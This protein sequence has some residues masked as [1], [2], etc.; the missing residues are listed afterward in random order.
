M[1]GERDRGRE[2][3]IEVSREGEGGRKIDRDGEEI[4]KQ[5]ESSKE[6]TEKPTCQGILSFSPRPVQ[7]NQ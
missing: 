1:E 5:N 6:H 2:R 7:L 4:T 3:E